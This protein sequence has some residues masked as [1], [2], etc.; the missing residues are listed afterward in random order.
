MIPQRLAAR[1]VMLRDYGLGT[2]LTARINLDPWQA[3]QVSF[4]LSTYDVS[5]WDVVSQNWVVPQGEYGVVIGRN[6]MEEGLSGKHC[7]GGC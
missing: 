5:Y 3:R 2:R 1:C 7:F 6:S 4:N